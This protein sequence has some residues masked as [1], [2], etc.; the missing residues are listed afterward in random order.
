M[1]TQLAVHART[2]GATN[3]GVG[4]DELDVV[5]VEVAILQRDVE[6]VGHRV[7]HA[8]DRLPGE[9]G[10]AVVH[11]VVG[12]LATRHADTAAD[13]A[14]QAII[15]TEVEQAVQ[16]ERESRRS[17]AEAALVEVDLGALVSGFGF[18][19]EAT[20]VVTD[21]RVEIITLVVVSRHGVAGGASIT[22]GEGDV[23]IFN[24]HHA[25]VD[26]DIPAV[27]ARQGR[28]GQGTGRKRSREGKLPHLNSPFKSVTKDC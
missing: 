4:R 18:E 7:T 13:E 27:V 3:G 2:G 10:V 24:D 25:G 16:H 5:L 1:G 9:T 22:G 19:A 20:E 28:G 23:L 6:V 15:G 11:Q 8:G 12:Q 26:A 21:I 14:L 17:A